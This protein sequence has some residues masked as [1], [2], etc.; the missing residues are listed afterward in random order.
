MNQ[1]FIREENYYEK[2]PA[3]AEIG[4]KILHLR[5]KYGRQ[6]VVLQNLSLNMFENT[7]TVLLGYN[8]AGKTTTMSILTGIHQPSGGTA[9]INGY[10]IRIDMN[11]IRKNLGFC[12]QDNV[13]FDD[14][15]VEEHFYF[16]CKLKG[17]TQNI[18]VKAEVE[19]YL[20]LLD[21]NIKVW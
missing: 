1:E 16:Y 13:L 20:R 10:D 15:T 14:L 12:P 11:Q 9:F 5:K 2:E 19:K 8:G 3:G 18:A 7:V 6:K 4:I 17:M 21:L